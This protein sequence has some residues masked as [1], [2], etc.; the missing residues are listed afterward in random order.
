[1]SHVPPKVVI[2]SLRQCP[3]T[4]IGIQGS[5]SLTISRYRGKLLARV[6]SRLPPELLVGDRHLRLFCTGQRLSPKMQAS[7]ESDV[8][9]CASF[10]VW[11]VG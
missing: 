10:P 9:H 4:H 1:M 7:R 8:L 11:H 6:P 5:V 2:G 3:F